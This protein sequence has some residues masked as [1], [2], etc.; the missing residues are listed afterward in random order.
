MSLIQGGPDCIRV[1]LIKT[2]KTYMYQAN[3]HMMTNKHQLKNT[4][5]LKDVKA[6]KKCSANLQSQSV[7]KTTQKFYCYNSDC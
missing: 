4:A 6:R 5:F 1:P 3:I 7:T 2:A